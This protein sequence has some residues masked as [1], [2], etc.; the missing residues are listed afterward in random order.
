MLITFVVAA[1][2]ASAFGGA[3]AVGFEPL[4]HAGIAPSTIEAAT[5]ITLHAVFRMFPSSV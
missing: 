2:P 1:V 5:H 3:A 4:L